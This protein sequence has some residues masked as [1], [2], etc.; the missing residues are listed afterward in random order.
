MLVLFVNRMDKL[1]KNMHTATTGA[2]HFKC[3]KFIQ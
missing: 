2:V 3:I 1:W